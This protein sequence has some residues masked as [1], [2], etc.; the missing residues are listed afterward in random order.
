MD[1]LSSQKLGDAVRDAFK[2]LEEY[3]AKSTQFIRLYAG[4]EY[5]M[6]DLE[7]E[8]PVNSM[9]LAATIYSYKLSSGIPKAMVTTEYTK[10]RPA[11]ETLR[12]ALDYLCDGIH[13]HDTIEEIVLDALF[14]FGIVKV[15]INSARNLKGFSTSKASPRREASRLPKGFRRTISFSTRPPKAGG[16]ASSLATASPW[17]RRRR[18]SPSYTGISTRSMSQATGTSCGRATGRLPTCRRIGRRKTHLVT[19]TDMSSGRYGCLTS[20]RS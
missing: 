11:A 14:G 1:V 17:T 6:N 7:L 8:S 20:E 18:G 13:L 5:A 4:K 9:E 10:L 12:M 3:R 19:G 15:G 2:D 16:S